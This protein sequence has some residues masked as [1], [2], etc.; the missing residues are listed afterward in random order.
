MTAICLLSPPLTSLSQIFPQGK[1][2]EVT[3]SFLTQPSGSG[4]SSP[5]P[6]QNGAK[7]SPAALRKIKQWSLNSWKTSP[8]LEGLSIWACHDTE[9]IKLSWLL[10]SLEGQ[11]PRNIRPFTTM[12]LSNNHRRPPSWHLPSWHLPS[13]RNPSPSSPHWTS[14]PAEL[15]MLKYILILQ[16]NIY[17]DLLLSKKR[18]EA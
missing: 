11:L 7:V 17:S 12:K 18:A 16:N 9:T 14:K 10:A 5:D 15:I 8:G 2:G 6:I 4:S 3:F 13:C 1:K